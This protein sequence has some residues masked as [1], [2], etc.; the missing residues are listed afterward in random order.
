MSRGSQTPTSNTTSSTSDAFK[1]AAD[2]AHNIAETGAE[3]AGMGPQMSQGQSTPTAPSSSSE[4][5]PATAV[6]IPYPK[7]VDYLT[8]TLAEIKQFKLE[9]DHL[10]QHT[11]SNS[12]PPIALIYG[13]TTPTVYG[14]KV[15]SREAIPRAD[16][17]DELAFASGDGVVLARAAM[18][19]EGYSVVRGGVVSSDRGHITLLGDLEAVGKCLV[20]VLGARR[21]GVGLGGTGIEASKVRSGDGLGVQMKPMVV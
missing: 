21:S 1:G 12:Y 7:A 10:P 6:T 5:N 4:P 3:S 9:L 11:A 14:A 17:Y 18:V 8:R 15:E 16:C 19:P 13:K 2:V 20:A